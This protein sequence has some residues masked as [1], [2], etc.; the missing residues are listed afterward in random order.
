VEKKD[1]DFHA[2]VDY[3]KNFIASFNYEPN[4]IY[5]VDKTGLYNRA[6]QDYTFDFKG[7]TSNGCKKQMQ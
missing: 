2:A 1:A 3:L 5:K 7:N 6:L 4:D